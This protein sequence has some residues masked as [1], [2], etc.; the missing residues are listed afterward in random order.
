LIDQTSLDIQ[1]TLENWLWKLEV[2][3]NSGYDVRRYT[4][5]VGGFEYSFYDIAESG[6]DLGMIMEYQYD[7]RV[8]DISGT[9]IY[10][11][12]VLGS[13]F[14]FN[15]EQSTELLI[16]MSVN[17]EEHNIFWNIE[18]SRRIG[19]NWKITIEAR[20]LGNIDEEN[21]TSSPYYAIRN[22]SFVMIEFGRYF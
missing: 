21:P 22:D 2:I 7:D 4:A 8:Q 15:D 3:S 6:I 13:R 18:G 1:A 10:D 12:V 11:S 9:T 5:A 14:A 19:D 16:G 20:I 17:D